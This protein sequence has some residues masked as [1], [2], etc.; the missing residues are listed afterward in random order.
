MSYSGSLGWRLWWTPQRAAGEWYIKGW[1]WEGLTRAVTGLEQRVRNMA[2][3][4]MAHLPRLARGK[5]ALYEEGRESEVSG[6]TQLW[7]RLKDRGEGSLYKRSLNKN[8]WNKNYWSWKNF[9]IPKK[10]EGKEKAFWKCLTANHVLLLAAA[11]HALILY[12]G[13]NFPRSW[14]GVTLRAFIS[15]QLVCGQHKKMLLLLPLTSR[16]IQQEPSDM[17][18]LTLGRVILSTSVQTFL[19]S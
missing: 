2:L 16:A 1:V 10:G 12:S 8:I 3:P 6:V 5:S 7:S 4:T 15:L 9:C 11:T 14:A 18:P 19:L 13:K 17:L